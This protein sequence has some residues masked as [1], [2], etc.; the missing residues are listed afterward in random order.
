MVFGGPVELTFHNQRNSAHR[1]FVVGVGMKLKLPSGDVSP[2][3]GPADMLVIGVIS[4]AVVK[5]GGVT[6]VFITQRGSVPSDFSV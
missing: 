5:V 2:S 6:K 4:R 1:H 3:N